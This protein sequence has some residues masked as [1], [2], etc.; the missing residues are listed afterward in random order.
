VA[1]GVFEPGTTEMRMQWKQ[2]MDLLMGELKKAPSTLRLAY[3]AE[4]EDEKLVEARLQMLKQETANLWA[5]Q[6]GPYELVIETEVFWR[7][8]APPKRSALK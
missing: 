5:Q 4:V 8:G 7:T 1:N 2:R 6:N 3:M